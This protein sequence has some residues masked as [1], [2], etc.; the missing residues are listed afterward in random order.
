M[1][2]EFSKLGQ[3]LT[4]LHTAEKCTRINQ[5]TLKLLQDEFRR[6]TLAIKAIW[7]DKEPNWDYALEFHEHEAQRLLNKLRIERI[8]YNM[9]EKRWLKTDHTLLEIYTRL[10]AMLEDFVRQL[11]LLRYGGYQYI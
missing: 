6:I 10:S 11:V 9:L 7:T 5:Q 8:N 1:E 2:N 3:L 4:D